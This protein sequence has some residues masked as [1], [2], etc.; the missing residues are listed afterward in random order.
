MRKRLLKTMAHHDDWL[1]RGPY[2]YEMDLHNYIRLSIDR[3]CNKL[4]EEDL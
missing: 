2:V 3:K 4:R 1:N